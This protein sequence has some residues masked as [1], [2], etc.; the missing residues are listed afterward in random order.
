MLKQL[1]KKDGIITIAEYI[2]NN[3]FEAHFN[4]KNQMVW[5][6]EKGCD[7]FNGLYK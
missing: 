4:E 1:F 7:N 5:E 6:I 2:Y 3:E